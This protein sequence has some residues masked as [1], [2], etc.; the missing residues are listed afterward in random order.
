MLRRKIKQNKKKESDGIILDGTVKVEKWLTLSM[1]GVKE[2]ME[3]RVKEKQQKRLK[4]IKGKPK[5]SNKI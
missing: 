4:S 5:R 2:E 3:V 1:D